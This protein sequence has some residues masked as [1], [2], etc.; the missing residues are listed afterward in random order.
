MAN[1]ILSRKNNA[2]GFTPKL[3][4][5]YSHNDKVSTVL[6]KT[7]QTSRADGPEINPQSTATKLLRKHVKSTL[8][9]NL[10]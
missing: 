6:H 8:K 3:K 2:S 4:V 1:T 5:Y 9:T 10:N 7:K